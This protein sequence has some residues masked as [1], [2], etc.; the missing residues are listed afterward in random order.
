MTY[1]LHAVYV[2]YAI[3]IAALVWTRSVRP[4]GAVV[5]H[6]ADVVVFSVLQYLTLGPSSPFFVYFV[7]SLFCGALRWEW[8]G[9][10]STAGGIVAAYVVMGALMSRSLG[11][12]EFELNHFIIRIAYLSVTA[13]LLVYLGRHEFRRRR[14]LTQLSRWPSVAGSDMQDNVKIILDHAAG[15]LGA[16]RVV[17]AWEVGEEP[18]VHVGVSDR[19]GVTLTRCS[20]E[21]VGDLVSPSLR[22]ATILCMGSLSEFPLIVANNAMQA[23]ADHAEIS[24]SIAKHLDGGM[25]SAPFQTDRITGRVFFTGVR[26]LTEAGVPLAEVVAREAGAS[27][28]HLYVAEERRQIAADEE[29]IRVARDLHDGVLQSLTGIRLEL[30]AVAD[31]RSCANWIRDKLFA[32]ERAIAIE[33]RE[34]RTFITGLGVQKRRADGGDRGSSLRESLDRLS[35]RIA[36]QWKV[37]V[38]IRVVRDPAGLSEAV[39]EAVPLM[40]HEAVVNAVKHA[41][42]S[43]VTVTVDAEATGVRILVADDGRGFP[44][45]GRL[46]HRALLETQVAAPVSLLERVTALGGEMWIES[47]DGGSTVEVVVA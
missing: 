39:A 1:G 33:Q 5:T 9:T 41:H 26:D 37:P 8:R 16:N 25:V 34:L 7:F 15:I 28:D 22:H 17:A 3:L 23:H 24:P 45:R 43:R 47:T 19:S 27:L 20:P 32:V 6:V 29:R 14:Q 2:A 42:P 4:L 36:T 13:A 40:V 21:H 30:R 46:D 12:N 35:D 38:T 18:F 11:P 31:D 10:L 44:F